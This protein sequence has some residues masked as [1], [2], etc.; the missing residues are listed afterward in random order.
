MNTSKKLLLVALAATLSAHAAAEY[1]DHSIK[2]VVP[3]AI[4]GVSDILARVVA[5]KI[6]EQTGKAVIVDNK[7]GAGG[8]IGYDFGAKASADG[9]TYVATDVTYT[10]MPALYATL[11]WNP[12]TDLVPVSLL[13]RMPFLIVVK[14]PSKSAKLTDLVAEAKAKPTVLNYGSAGTGTVIQVVTELFAN[15][16]GIQITQVPY[17]GMGEA[18]NGLLSGSVNLLVVAMPTA[19][20]QV[21]GGTVTALGVTSAQRSAALPNIPTATEAGVPFV[22]SNW[23]GFTAPK[24]TPREATDWMQKAVAAA[25]VTQQ[26]KDSF[27]AQGAE[28]SGSGAEPFGKFMQSETSRWGQVI[29]TAKIVA[30]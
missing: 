29:K 22:A 30:E 23:V 26:V 24:N 19:M 14:G 3:F 11:P 25:L 27:A 12:T 10:M 15:T 5:Q 13:A 8:R 16:A 18:M 7:T 9:Y 20:G 4:G 21:K 6:T 2:I 28:L 1:P 17:R